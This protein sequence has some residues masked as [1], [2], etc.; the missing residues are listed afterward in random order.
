MTDALEYINML[1]GGLID[2]L[3]QTYNAIPDSISWILS[4]F[5]LYCAFR[6]LIL[7]I[8]GGRAIRGS[9]GARK[10]GVKNNNRFSK[11]SSDD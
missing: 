10:S 6:F 11:D 8:A 4:I 3:N 2:W 7:P 5:A 1:F 9:D